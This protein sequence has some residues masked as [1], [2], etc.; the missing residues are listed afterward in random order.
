MFIAMAP[1][2]VPLAIWIYTLVFAFASLWFAHY[3]LAALQR[4][5]AVVPV[6]VL[7]A[8]PQR[9]SPPDPAEDAKRL[10]GPESAP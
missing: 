6:E 2:L 4:M 9:V 1:L 7:D 8:D 5:R 10:G 3:A